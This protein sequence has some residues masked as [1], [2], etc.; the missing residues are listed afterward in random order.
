MSGWDLLIAFG[1]VHATAAIIV[2]LV[3]VPL[4]W[5]KDKRGGE[6]DQESD[7]AFGTASLEERRKMIAG[8]YPWAS[9]SKSVYTNKDTE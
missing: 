3:I 6:P 9:M 2:L 8:E 5:V 7:D 1:Y 4:L